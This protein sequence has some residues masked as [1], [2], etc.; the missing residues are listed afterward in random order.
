MTYEVNLLMKS[1][2]SLGF[3]DIQTLQN[4]HI[5]AFTVSNTGDKRVQE[6]WLMTKGP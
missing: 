5:L 3:G 2:E 6:S 4:S 1:V